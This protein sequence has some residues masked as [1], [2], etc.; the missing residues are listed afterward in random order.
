MFEIGAAKNG[1]VGGR[2][3]DAFLKLDENVRGRWS[4]YD[5]A[6]ASLSGTFDSMDE[7]DAED[8]AFDANKSFFDFE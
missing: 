4:A 1:K 8:G 5:Q 2:I 6:V 7:A 3:R